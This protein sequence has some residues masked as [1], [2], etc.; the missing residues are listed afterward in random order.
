MVLPLSTNVVERLSENS[1]QASFCGPT[2]LHNGMKR[3]SHRRL[4]LPKTRDP[5]R[6]AIFQTVSRRIIL[7]SSPRI[8]CE[9]IA[10]R[11]GLGG[12]GPTSEQLPFFLA[13]IHPSAW[14]GYSP[15]FASTGVWEVLLAEAADN[16]LPSRPGS[17]I[18]SGPAARIPPPGPPGFFVRRFAP[19]RVEMARKVHGRGPDLL[20]QCPTEAGGPRRGR[21]PVF[22][23]PYGPVDYPGPVPPQKSYPD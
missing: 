2:R 20:R 11:Y 14:K 16:R 12:V 9:F 18:P 13:P 7:R 21:R 10:A 5:T 6:P 17:R 3:Y 1:E 23:L 15:N 22:V 19:A 4:A 8:H